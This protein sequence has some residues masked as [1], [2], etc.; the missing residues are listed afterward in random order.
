MEEGVEDLLADESAFGYEQS[1]SSAAG[2]SSDFYSTSRHSA[3][4]SSKSR[5]DGPPPLPWRHCLGSSRKSHHRHSDSR[6]LDSLAKHSESHLKQRRY[7]AVNR[8]REVWKGDF[9]QRYG[10]DPNQRWFEI[11]TD[12]IKREKLPYALVNVLVPD[13]TKKDASPSRP[14]YRTLRRI[15]GVCRHDPSHN[16]QEVSDPRDPRRRP[17]CPTRLMCLRYPI[18]DYEA[19]APAR[20]EVA[21]IGLNDNVR[22]D[23]LREF[24]SKGGREVVQL[25]IYKH[26]TT[27]SHMGMALVEFKTTDQTMDF[28]KERGQDP[29]VMGFPSTLFVDT[30]GFWVTDEY[31]RLTGEPPSFNPRRRRYLTK[32]EGL[33]RVRKLIRK[34]NAKDNVFDNCA[35][36][37]AE[38]EI[39]LEDLSGENNGEEFVYQKPAG[40]RTPTG[41]P[42]PGTD[43]SMSRSP[44]TASLDVGVYNDTPPLTE[45]QENGIHTPPPR[46]RPRKHEASRSRNSDHK[47]RESRSH[48]SRREPSRD[49]S[50]RN[51]SNGRHYHS[52]EKNRRDRSRSPRGGRHSKS[53]YSSH[54][55]DRR[56]SSHRHR[57]SHRKRSVS[58]SSTR[59]NSSNDDGRRSARR[60]TGGSGDK[61]RS[62]PKRR[63]RSPSQTAVQSSNSHNLCMQPPP[64]P[65]DLHIPSPAANAPVP[66]IYTQVTP[67]PS[68][69]ALPTSSPKKD[70]PAI[71]KE[72]LIQVPR[73]ERE[74]GPFS[75]VSMSQ[76]TAMFNQMYTYGYYDENAQFILPT[77]RMHLDYMCSFIIMEPFTE[78]AP[79]PPTAKDA[80]LTAI[81]DAKT[82]LRT[83]LLVN[84]N[85]NILQRIETHLHKEIDRLHAE[86]EENQRKESAMRSKMKREEPKQIFDFDEQFRNTSGMGTKSV[87][88]SNWHSERIMTTKKIPK[89]NAAHPQKPEVAA[90][91]S[92]EASPV[93][94]PAISRS[95]SRLSISS[96]AGSTHT[97]S[98][99]RTGSSSVISAASV[100]ETGTQKSSVSNGTSGKTS[101]SLT[102]TTNSSSHSPA[103]PHSLGEVTAEDQFAID[104]ALGRK[105]QRVD[106]YEDSSSS[107]AGDSDWA[108][109][110]GIEDEL[111]GK[112]KKQKHTHKRKLSTGVKKDANPEPVKTK[113][114]K[115]SVEKIV[116]VKEEPVSDSEN[117]QP[118]V[119]TE[120]P[121][122]EVVEAKSLSPVEVVPPPPV[123][124]R[125]A[126]VDVKPE[127]PPEVPVVAPKKPKK[128]RPPPKKKEVVVEPPPEPLVVDPRFANI[129]FHPRNP[130]ENARNLLAP[131]DDEDARYAMAY[132]SKLKIT[133]TIQLADKKSSRQCVFNDPFAAIANDPLIPADH[134]IVAEGCARMRPWV[135]G[136]PKVYCREQLVRVGRIEVN[137]KDQQAARNRQEKR[138]EMRS[139]QRNLAT[140]SE[141]P[142]IR[143]NQM[144]FREKMLKFARSSIHGWGLF[145]LEDIAPNDMIIEYVGEIIRSTVADAREVN[146]T[147]LGIGSSYLFRMDEDFVIDATKK[148]NIARFINHSCNPNCYARVLSLN[149]ADPKTICIY[150]KRFISK[151]EE[152]TYDYKFPLE[153]EKIRCFC[154]A[155]NCRRY[156]N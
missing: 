128:P 85:A 8:G 55:R 110:N 54:D 10:R 23:Y 147:K 78:T 57:R 22:E 35:R 66:P 90:R 4:S 74:L 43:S 51:E 114:R 26:P 39:K 76:W 95:A 65:T 41:M 102:G 14:T 152:I 86:Y 96:D 106:Y 118:E 45:K 71:P 53:R 20:R 127:I 15:N 17:D 153:D 40:A 30:L 58:S 120:Q 142:L 124:V 125:E 104:E 50:R 130:I 149:K 36:E 77:V 16:V 11:E 119:I 72:A 151:G 112:K 79:T 13:E 62:D 146:Y 111:V 97:S 100:V 123:E 108:E 38:V 91:R 93:F 29:K 5:R 101:A 145:T 2:S 134:P 131:M 49:R 61:R 135:P 60:R 105:T 6:A 107:A 83:D 87:F 156:L 69:S 63:H 144:K 64:A 19:R 34:Q 9:E 103:R 24:C 67:Q 88:G 99:D 92:V 48:R 7:E 129:S 98:R 75:L 18:N 81:S 12:L 141:S 37:E 3:F 121:T 136:A 143:Q 138:R 80:R 1:T 116:E 155:D 25:H 132:G 21:F 56:S 32:E 82:K 150:A 84:L 117:S 46:E 68:T 42:A 33:E 137:P 31:T 140:V 52:S 139:L 89:K 73:R 133:T 27:K 122:P 28:I 113:K 115:L 47:R 126:I 44:S 148:G 70:V 109:Q 94:T 59:S 154:G